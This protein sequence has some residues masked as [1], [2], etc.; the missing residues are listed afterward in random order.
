[1]SRS[2]KPYPG[3][4]AF[5]VLLEDYPGE[6]SAYAGANTLKRAKERRRELPQWPDHKVRI[7]P[8]E[9]EEK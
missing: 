8:N 5:V 1:V 6:W 9:P 4:G 3:M 2:R 7:V